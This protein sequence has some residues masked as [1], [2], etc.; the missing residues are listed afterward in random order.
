MSLRAHFAKQSPLKQENLIEWYSLSKR[1]SLSDA[2]FQQAGT[3][4]RGLVCESALGGGEWGPYP[5][6]TAR[7]PE[8]FGSLNEGAFKEISGP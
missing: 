8:M 5:V 2:Y 7:F 3:K 6:I 1:G 4:K